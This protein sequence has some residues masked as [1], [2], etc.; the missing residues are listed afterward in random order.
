MNIRAR[1]TLMFSAIVIILLTGASVSIY[2]FSADYRHDDFYRR[3][4]S[5][6]VNTAKLLIEVEE[7]DAEL[8]RRIE[9]D[10]P[11]NLPREQIIIFNYR[12]EE[13]YS[14]DVTDIIQID[15]T[16]L[17]EIRLNTEIEFRQGEYEVLGFMFVEQYDRFAVIAAATDIYGLSKLRNLRNILLLVLAIS[18]V[19]VPVSGWLYAGK[20]LH[21]I[22]TLVKQTE[23]ITATEL[24]RRLSTRNTTDEIGQLVQTINHMLDRLE[25]AFHAQ[26]QFIANASHELRTPLTS[27]TGEIEVTLIQ[28]RS[29]EK[30]QAVLQSV[31]EEVR[32]LS[33]LS[34]QLLLLAQTSGEAPEHSLGSV[35]VDE[36]L[37]QAKEEV[38]RNNPSGKVEIDMDPTL[39]EDQ[40]TVSGDEQLLKIALLNQLD[41]G[42]KYS[43]KDSVS[44]KVKSAGG[45][46][47]M[48]FE[49][50]GIGIDPADLPNIYE[51]FFRGRN[52]RHRRGYGIGLSLVKRII[53]VHKG[54]IRVSSEPGKLTRFTVAIPHTRKGHL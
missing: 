26:K 51:P 43:S 28:A 13:L 4:K 32:G 8:L 34:N 7:V 35:R 17:S 50:E 6:A 40:L 23:T 21:P 11:T 29:S 37:W 36:L 39:D 38:E 9:R 49:N 24:S 33:L 31:L 19:V 5:K 25:M 30:Y 10:N 53:G 14:S 42:I 54:T 47:V 12:N 27:I 46:V 52:T 15:S 18:M 1:L 22:S 44:V 2:F 20:A 48:S 16:I 41:N 45:S 3:L